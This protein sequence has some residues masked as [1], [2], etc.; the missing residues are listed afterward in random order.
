MEELYLIREK[1]AQSDSLA[2]RLEGNANIQGFQLKNGLLQAISAKTGSPAMTL[3]GP[4]L[5]D[6]NGRGIDASYGLRPLDKEAWLLTLNF[7]DNGLQYPLLIDPS[8]TTGGAPVMSSIRFGHAAVLLPNGKVLVVGGS[9][10]SALSTAELYDP[11]AGT[12]ATTNG[13]A[14]ARNPTQAILLPTGKVLAMAGDLSTAELYDPVAGT[15]ATTNSLLSARD[16]RSTLTLMA[17]GKVLVTGGGTA[18]LCSLWA[19][20]HTASRQ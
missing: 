2:F 7:D 17:N 15:W 9:S 6:A 8:W 18:S 16:D 12:W 11:V 4:K 3:S 19:S 10:G 20:S 14:S 1:Q 13:M 5:F